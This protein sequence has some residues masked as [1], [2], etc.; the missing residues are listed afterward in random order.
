VLCR[1]PRNNHWEARICCQAAF[2]F[3]RMTGKAPDPFFKEIAAAGRR[4]RARAGAD[5]PAVFVRY[6]E[7][8]DLAVS[9]AVGGLWPK[10]NC[11]PG[12]K[13]A[14]WRGGL[15][16]GAK[17]RIRNRTRSPQNGNSFDD[18]TGGISSIYPRVS[19]VWTRGRSALPTSARP[20]GFFEGVTV[21]R[22]ASTTKGSISRAVNRR[23][24][25]ERVNQG[26]AAAGHVLRASC[27]EARDRPF[28]RAWTGAVL[29]LQGLHRVCPFKAIASIR[30][31]RPGERLS[32][33]FCVAAALG[34]VRRSLHAGD[35]AET[36][37][38]AV[39]TRRRVRAQDRRP[40]AIGVPTQG[41]TRPEPHRRR[42]A[43]RQHRGHAAAGSTRSS[44]S[45]PSRR[46]RTESWSWPATPATATTRRATTTRSAASRC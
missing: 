7:C 10:R 40:P 29:G 22:R 43:Q 11:S 46:V 24:T 19:P 15:R 36:R 44:F 5:D 25:S 32:L 8:A 16:R 34:R 27:R 2:K 1:Q 3:S 23:R 37:V 42:T 21:R 17:P 12:E 41:R 4:L 33:K 14:R 26:L 13:N 6:R 28:R 9:S 35:S 18:E 38:A 20:P 39:S 30:A 31:G 45:R